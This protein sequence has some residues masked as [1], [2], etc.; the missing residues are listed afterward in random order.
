MTIATKL[1]VIQALFFDY[2]T[3]LADGLG[4]DVAWPEVTFETTTGADGQMTPYLK[5]DLLPNRPA[6]EG[7]A[8]GRLDQGIL[9]LTLNWPPGA[10]LLKPAIYIGQIIE[11]FPKGFRLTG[12]GVSVKISAETWAAAPI[13]EP[14]RA[15]HPITIT[16]TA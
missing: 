14:D 8:S 16:W 2:V 4:I 12:P 3:S 13:T 15:M 5:V 11:S 9:Q 10:G 1:A 6:W 7:V